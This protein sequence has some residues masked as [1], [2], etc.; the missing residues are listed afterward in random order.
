MVLQLKRVLE[1]LVLWGKLTW[2]ETFHAK[3]RDVMGTY[4]GRKN[5]DNADCLEKEYEI[6]GQQEA[7][8]LG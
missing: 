3:R 7:V 5:N 4:N 2:Q 6:C 8:T 1:K